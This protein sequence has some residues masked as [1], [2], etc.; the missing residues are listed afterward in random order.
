[1]TCDSTHITAPDGTGKSAQ[2]AMV[3]ALKMAKLNT[4]DIDYVN[5]HATS[6]VLG[7]MAENAAV[8]SLFGDHAYKMAISSTKS[9]TGHLLG[10]S[11]GVETVILA[12]VLE[13]GQ[14]PPTINLDNPDEGFDLNYVPHE[15]QE[16]SVKYCMTNNFGFG[17]HNV[18]LI[19]GKV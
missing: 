15:A 10:A 14:L 6:T 4:T 7:D 1:M 19:L 13:T 2:Q 9:M 16:R 12:K 3:V 11:G 17:G 5:P 18:S 8:K